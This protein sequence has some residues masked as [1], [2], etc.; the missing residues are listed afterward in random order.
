ML[1]AQSFLDSQGDALADDAAVALRAACE[2]AVAGGSIDRLGN[3]R[4]A[5]ELVRKAAAARDLRIY[6]L[7]GSSGVP[8]QDELVTVGVGDVMDAY[9]ELDE[10]VAP[11]L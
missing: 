3:G 2:A 11:D 9:Q 8:S 10:G 4:F 6:E 5:R 1:I 7:H